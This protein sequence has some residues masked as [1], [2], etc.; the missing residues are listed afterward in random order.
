VS[1]IARGLNDARPTLKQGW[2]PRGWL[3]TSST[4]TG[5]R[6]VARARWPRSKEH[7]A[8]RVEASSASATGR[9]LMDAWVAVL[10]RRATHLSGRRL[11]TRRATQSQACVT[12]GLEQ[13]DEAEEA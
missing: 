2:P 12:Q 6:A 5:S 9:D 1:E 10:T 4:R 11:T 13:A 7:Q 8:R 3:S